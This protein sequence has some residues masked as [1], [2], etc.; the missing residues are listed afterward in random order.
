MN[1][2]H[3]WQ[4]SRCC[5]GLSFMMR[6]N[7]KHA[8]YENVGDLSF[9]HTVDT[10]TRRHDLRTTTTDLLLFVMFSTCRGDTS[11]LPI[12]ECN[13]ILHAIMSSIHRHRKGRWEARKHDVR[14]PVCLPTSPKAVAIWV[15]EETLGPP[16]SAGLQLPTEDC[17]VRGSM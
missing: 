7:V 17:S 8:I 9:V 1:V 13:I 12:N 3:D 16:G 4:A 15:N 14:G 2:E 10:N 11:M 6:F 5:G